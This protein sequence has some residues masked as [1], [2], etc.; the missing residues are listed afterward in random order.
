MQASTGTETASLASQ[1]A[2]LLPHWDR[3]FR[4]LLNRR[5]RS[6]L[7]RGPAVDLSPA[8]LQALS[9]LA[10]SDLRMGDLAQY[11]GLAESSVTRLVDRL[12]GAGFV[13]R[14]PSGL[15]RRSVVAG[16]TSAGRTLVRRLEEDRRALL[17]H[18]LGGLEPDERVDA[19]RLFGRLADTLAARQGDPAS[20]AG[21]RP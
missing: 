7:Y 19:V 11:L 12:A 1:A 3:F 20:T 15:D 18:L 9:A 8:Q 4:S 2:D 6:T 17:I 10:R 14:R 16:L 21:V 13:E 5:L